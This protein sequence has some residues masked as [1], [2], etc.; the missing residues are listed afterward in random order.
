MILL[1]KIC[2]VTAI[3]KNSTS[4]AFKNLSVGDWVHFSIPMDAVGRSCRGTYASYIR[5]RNLRTGA[6]SYLSFNQ[7]GKILNKFEWEEITLHI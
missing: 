2:K 5:C 7:I 3:H 6:E 4:E 1:E